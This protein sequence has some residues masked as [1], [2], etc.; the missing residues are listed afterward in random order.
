[1][2]IIN[3]AYLVIPE[4][5]MYIYLG[6]NVSKEMFE[7]ALEKFRAIWK[8]LKGKS[9]NKILDTPMGEISVKDINKIG[10]LLSLLTDLSQSPISLQALTLVH[11]LDVK[12][13]E[14]VSDLDLEL[15]PD[16][17]ELFKEIY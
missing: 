9:Y 13:W 12:K 11:G 17:Y 3:N 2:V 6:K 14:V 7:E 4:Y 1:M 5:E 8:L 15:N 16:R 10:H